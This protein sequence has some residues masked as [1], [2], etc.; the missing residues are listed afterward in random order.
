MYEDNMQ[1]GIT[2]SDN[3]IQARIVE[4]YHRL[5]QLLDENES[6]RSQ[7]YRLM[8]GSIGEHESSDLLDNVKSILELVYSFS[9][10]LNH[11]QEDIDN[12]LIASSLI[13]TEKY[14]LIFCQLS[15]YQKNQHQ[16]HNPRTCDKN[17]KHVYCDRHN[18][19]KCIVNNCGGNIQ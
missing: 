10:E 7:I 9:D 18:L 14:D 13:N 8:E 15:T 3:P 12:L 1:G 16:V 6:N 11:V 19:M 17:S 2:M 4:I 5:R